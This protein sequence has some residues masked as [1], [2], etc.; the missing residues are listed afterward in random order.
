MVMVLFVK[1]L[2]PIAGSLWRFLSMVLQNEALF[3]CY[4]FIENAIRQKRKRQP[5]LRPK[6]SKIKA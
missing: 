2:M 5:D 1:M 6:C 4:D 3:V